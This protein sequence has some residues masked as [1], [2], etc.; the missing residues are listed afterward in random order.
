VRVRGTM[1]EVKQIEILQD[2]IYIRKNIERID[3]SVEDG[4]CGWEYDE[5]AMPLEQYLSTIEVLGR[6]ITSLM[7]GV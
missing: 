6:Q 7:L 3:E 5:V 2:K 4:F 1:A